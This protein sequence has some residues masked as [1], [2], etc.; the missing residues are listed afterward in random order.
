M[1]SYISFL[2]NA[3]RPLRNPLFRN[4]PSF[5]L[6]KIWGWIVRLLYWEQF[7][8]IDIQVDIKS[9]PTRV[10]APQAPPTYKYRNKK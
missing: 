1:A 10:D 5:G 4:Q 8:R 6:L 3:T 2:L 7:I 9:S